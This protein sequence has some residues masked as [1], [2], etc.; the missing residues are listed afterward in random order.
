MLSANNLKVDSGLE[1][2]PCKMG[3]FFLIP[4]FMIHSPILNYKTG[5]VVMKSSIPVIH[6]KAAVLVSVGKIAIKNV[7]DP[8]ADPGG[9]VIGVKACGICSTDVKM[10]RKGQRDLRCPR[11]L[12]HEVV[13]VVIESRTDAF[14]AGDR[15]QIF[16]GVV[17]G[18]CRNCRTGRDNLCPK[19]KIIGFSYDGGF[20]E[21]MKVPP[22]SVRMAGLNRI[23]STLGYEKATLTEPLACCLNCAEK[24]G[25]SPDDTVLILGAGTMGLLNASIAK[26]R[27]ARVLVAEVMRERTELAKKAGAD[28]VIDPGSEDLVEVVHE[29]TDGRGAD[30]IIPAFGGAVALYPVFDLLAKGGRLCLFSGLPDSESIK[31]IDL[32]S[33]HYEEK[34][35]VGAYGC[36]SSHNRMAINLL[37]K[38]L[39]LDWLTVR[40]VRLD[41]IEEGLRSAEEKKQLRAVVTN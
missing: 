18:E 40:A 19:I 26:L 14:S 33:I 36:T 1:K 31:N 30:A 3:I 13:G 6:M 8:V 7:D 37:A 11:I 5:I 10:W 25:I 34:M 23:P 24:L 12:G 21:M 32:N 39:S 16:P 38:D 29:E 22:E 4:I 15:V 41:D 27:G 2:L 35:L 28:R 17:C 20:A 9:L